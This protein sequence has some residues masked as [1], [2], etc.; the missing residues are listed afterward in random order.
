MPFTLLKTDRSFMSGIPGDRVAEELLVGIIALGRTLGM[1]VI[2]EGVETAEQQRRLLGLGCRVAQGFHLGRPAPA[3]VIE[4][5]WNT[6]ST[7]VVSQRLD[8]EP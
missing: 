7:A 5:R 4:A 8:L 6:D 2:V 1:R 3:G